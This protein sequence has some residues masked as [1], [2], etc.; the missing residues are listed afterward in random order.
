[1]A[2]LTDGVRPAEARIFG[3]SGIPV[4]LRWL[5]KDFV[6]ADRDIRFVG[7][8]VRDIFF[9]CAPKDF[10]LCTDAS[11]DEMKVIAEAC[12]YVMEVYDTGIAHGTLTFR[13]PSG[14]YEITCL[15]AESDHDG[16]HATCEFTRD[17]EGDLARRD[18][19]INAMAMDFDGRIYDP[20]GGLDDLNNKRIR[21]VGDP[22]LRIQED[23]LRILRWIR[24]H[25]RFAGGHAL[26]DAAA[27]AA[28]LHGPGLRTISRERVWMEMQKIVAGPS[29]P[30]MIQSMAALNLLEPID[31]DL[32]EAHH[33]LYPATHALTQDP[34]TLMVALAGSQMLTQR[35]GRDWKWSN[36]EKAKAAFLAQGMFGP[37]QRL[38]WYITALRKPKDWV[39]ELAYLRG[40][41]DAAKALRE[42][43]FPPFPVTGDDLIALGFKAGPQIGYMLNE[44]RTAWAHED[45]RPTREELLVGIQPGMV[46][47]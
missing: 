2:G 25:G 20:F 19:T 28:Q 23:Y 47:S 38:D 5:R 22:N 10:D 45:C 42:R 33:T 32:V 24:F 4:Y 21:F 44:L 46:L 39:I 3:E 14:C 37:W 16:R 9:G 7:G 41:P 26:D 18:L 34:I 13:L 6:A 27:Q 17:W 40:L 30:R 43:E 11:I 35:I 15:R 29:G 1:M 36:E 12:P 31:L 8:C